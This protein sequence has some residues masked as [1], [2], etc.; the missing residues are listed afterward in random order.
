MAEKFFHQTNIQP[1]RVRRRLAAAW[2]RNF[3]AWF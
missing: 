1:G 2:F 3:R